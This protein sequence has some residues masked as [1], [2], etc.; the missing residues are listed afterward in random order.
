MRG[1]ETNSSKSSNSS[2]GRYLMGSITISACCKRP[3]CWK[4]KTFSYVGFALIFPFALLWK[5]GAPSPP[6]VDLKRRERPLR[7]AL[8]PSDYPPFLPPCIALS[9]QV[10]PS[11]GFIVISFDRKNPNLLLIMLFFSGRAGWQRL[12]APRQ[13]GREA[14]PPAQR[15]AAAAAFASR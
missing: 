9:K 5:V 14:A 1:G 3:C 15:T 2:K 4:S 6:A 10:F 8:A 13:R 12:A 11:V 7:L